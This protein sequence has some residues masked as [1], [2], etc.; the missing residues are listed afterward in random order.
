MM[1]KLQHEDL[2]I[3]YFLKERNNQDFVILDKHELL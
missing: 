2:S 3:S 1:M